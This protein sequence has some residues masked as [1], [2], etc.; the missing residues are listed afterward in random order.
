M[1]AGRAV[2]RR[3]VRVAGAGDEL[4]APVAERAAA[5]AAVGV[6]H[7]SLD[8]LQAALGLH[9][10][11]GYRVQQRPRVRMLGL[12]EDGRHLALLHHGAQ[13]HHDHLVRQLGDDP[14]VVG[15]EDHRHAVGV[16]QPAQQIQHLGLNGDVDRRGRLVGHQQARAAGQRHG[17]QH[18]LPHAA[19]QL[20]DVGI[21]QGARRGDADLGQ[22]V[23]ATVAAGLPGEIGV[24]QAERLDDLAADRVHGAQRAHRF[25]EDHGD[26]PA[27]DRSELL[28]L[29]VE[30]RQVHDAGGGGFRAGRPGRDGRAVEADAAGDD[31]AGRRDD[32]QDGARRHRLAAAA[33][34]DDADDALFGHPER[35]TVHGA[36]H[37]QIGEEPRAQPGDVQ[38]RLSGRA[39]G[40][41]SRFAHAAGRR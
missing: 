26:L 15:D 21:D 41:G 30:T 39:V 28:A 7:R 19:R 22:Q 33:L 24:V 6:R 9:A 8:R 31:P 23:R 18:A 1:A 36:D 13:V 32:A 38:K 35:Q 4:P 20:E 10:D 16:V 5:R 11:A 27:A 17:D 29:R 12:V 37:P 2:E 34:S 3:Q 40:A 25:L 14:H